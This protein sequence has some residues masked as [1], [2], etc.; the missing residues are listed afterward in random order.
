[1]NS[2]NSKQYSAETIIIFVL[3]FLTIAGV[4]Y[5]LLKPSEPNFHICPLC[6]QEVK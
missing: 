4:G 1:M 2:N 6:E 3:I 5:N